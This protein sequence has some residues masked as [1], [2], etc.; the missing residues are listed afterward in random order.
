MVGRQ[1]LAL[2]VAAGLAGRAA[3]ARAARS[4]GVHARS[5]RWLGHRR[6][7]GNAGRGRGADAAEVFDACELI[8]K[9][10]ELPGGR[11]V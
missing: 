5:C 6:A 11:A 8:V 1:G 3:G 2:A 10:K 7:R 4:G 9:V